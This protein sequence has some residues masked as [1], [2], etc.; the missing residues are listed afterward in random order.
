MENSKTKK[1]LFTKSKLWSINSVA[2][3]IDFDWVDRLSHNE[4]CEMH[5]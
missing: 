5:Q 4:T 2:W 1:N 3:S